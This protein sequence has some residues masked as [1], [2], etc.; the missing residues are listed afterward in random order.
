MTCGKWQTGQLLYLKAN[1]T[2]KRNFQLHHLLARKAHTCQF[3]GIKTITK[4]HSQPAGIM[5][6]AFPAVFVRP[7]WRMRNPSTDQ[8]P[9]TLSTAM[10]ACVCWCVVEVKN[11]RLSNYK[12]KTRC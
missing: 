8:T 5:H 4:Y 10:L 1:K 9:H 3:A 11:V 12:F 2:D 6:I 7:P